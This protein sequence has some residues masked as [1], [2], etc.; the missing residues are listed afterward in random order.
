MFAVVRFL[1]DFDE[2]RHVIPVTD[3][4]D[5][6]PANGSDFNKRATY[7]AFL[8]DPVDDEDTEFY[9]AQILMLA[10]TSQEQKRNRESA[11]EALYH[12]ILA[13]TLDDA[14]NSVEEAQRPTG[15]TKGGSRK[16]RKQSHAAH[17]VSESSD[18]D[19][20]SLCARSEP[21]EMTEKMKM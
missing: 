17:V 12:K 15:K 19:S 3:I 20:D 1:D 2:K 6:R 16:H 9:N 7:T 21:K 4:K 5:F 11:K 10:G 8:R 14:H 13:N 18:S